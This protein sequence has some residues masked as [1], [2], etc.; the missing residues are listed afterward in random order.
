MNPNMGLAGMAS[1]SSVPYA[2][3]SSL[4]RKSERVEE[5]A[6]VLLKLISGVCTPTLGACVETVD[7]ANHQSSLFSNPFVVTF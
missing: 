4:S 1:D 5:C 3:V 6:N 2:I 7:L